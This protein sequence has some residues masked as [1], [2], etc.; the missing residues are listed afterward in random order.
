MG[1][2]EEKTEEAKDKADEAKEKRPR[3]SLLT[4]VPRLARFVYHVS[5]DPRVPWGVKGALVG[6]A[7]Y[8]ASPI[9]IIPDWIPAAGYLDD[10]LVVGFV[11]SYVLARVPPEVVRE[12]WGEDVQTLERIRDLARRKGKREG[13]EAVH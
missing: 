1:D 10:V 13:D 6:L 2:G 11:V 3:E 4:L 12:H 7:A 8:L 5:R 9:D